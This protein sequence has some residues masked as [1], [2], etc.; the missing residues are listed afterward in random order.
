MRCELVQPCEPVD[1]MLPMLKLPD[2]GGAESSVVAVGNA[3]SGV[4][5][6]A[7]VV[8][9]IFGV[10]AVETEAQLIHHGWRE[11]VVVAERG[12]VIP[13]LR[14]H[15]ADLDEG[16]AG[17][18]GGEVAALIGF[19]PEEAVAVAELIVGLDVELVVVIGLDRVGFVVVADAGLIGGSRPDAIARD[20]LCRD[21][22]ETVCRNLPGVPLRRADGGKRRLGRG[23][24]DGTRELA[25][26]EGA[27]R[28]QSR[29]ARVRM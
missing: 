5:V 16:R 4:L 21:G 17:R 7:E 27:L 15:V 10:E 28:H 25:L 1:A 18:W 3:E 11:C 12:V 13:R 14:V 23:I 9:K 20:H 29:S 22:I 2:P 6:G 24:V 26:Q 8:A 19:A